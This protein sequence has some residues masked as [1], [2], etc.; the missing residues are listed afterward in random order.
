MSHACPGAEGGNTHVQS[1]THVQV[2][3][4]PPIESRD[5]GARSRRA[6]APDIAAAEEGAGN[7]RSRAAPD[8]PTCSGNIS[9]R[10]TMPWHV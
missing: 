6:N 9:N 2:D 1:K 5:N 10:I 4:G 8:W 3:L 7:S